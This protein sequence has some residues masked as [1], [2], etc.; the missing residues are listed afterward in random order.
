MIVVKSF[1][2]CKNLHVSHYLFLDGTFTKTQRTRSSASLPVYL[3]SVGC[4]GYEEKL[5]NCTHH[6]YTSSTS[7][8]ISISCI[9][10]GDSVDS[11]SDKMSAA[12]LSIAVIF[13]FAVI[14]L[15]AVLIIIGIFRRR[16]KR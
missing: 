9:N 12:S 6:E 7:M 4:Y 11:S 10:S 15:V 3:T 2:L 8:D 13:A 16:T 1:I 14:I 5:I